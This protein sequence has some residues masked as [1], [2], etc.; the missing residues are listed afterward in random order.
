[1]YILNVGQNVGGTHTAEVLT[2]LGEYT[3]RISP[4]KEVMHICKGDRMSKKGSWLFPA[5]VKNGDNLEDSTD[6]LK[7]LGFQVATTTKNGKFHRVSR[8]F[9]WR[10]V[11]QNTNLTDVVEGATVRLQMHY[12][13]G[14]VYLTVPTPL[15]HPVS[16]G[17]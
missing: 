14:T 12:T 9:G 10:L 17:G 11:R 5:L 2:H 4:H 1:V 3:P 15:T 7:N 6:L 16:E 8:R 13:Q